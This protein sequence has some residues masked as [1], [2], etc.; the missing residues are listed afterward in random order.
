[1][2]ILD[3]PDVLII[4]AGPSGAIAAGILV[5][6]GWQVQILER[7]QFPRFVIGESLLPQCMAFIEEAGMLDAVNA[8]GFQHKNG[9]AFQRRGEHVV[10]DF[11][12][13]FSPGP[14]TT[15]QVQ[16]AVFDQVLADEA[17]RQ[18]ARIH[19]RHEIIAVDVS[20]EQA[21][22]RY[23]TPEGTEGEIRP[24]FLLDA[25]GYGRVLPRLLDLHRPSNF[26]VRQACFTHVKDGIDNPAFDR[27]KILITTHPEQPD[28]W[29]WTIPFSNG[30]CSLGVV[31]RQEFFAD[32]PEDGNTRLMQIVHED[33]YLSELLAKAEI[34]RPVQ[35][36][37]GYSANVSSLHG[38]HFALLGN[39]GEFLDP[40]FSSGVTVGMKSASLAAGLLNRQLRGESVD[41]ETEFAI[42]LKKGVDAFRT[43]VTGWYDQRFQDIIYHRTHLT[44]VK[45]MICSIL[46]GYAWDE[47]NPYVKESERR[48]NVLAEICRQDR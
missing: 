38:P 36:I 40:V 35:Q 4:G 18:G 43:F 7:E 5:Q 29:Y 24:R 42:P 21:V 23:R 31:A 9:A 39:A 2:N 37:T 47:K 33:P 34:I 1:M 46:A 44:H 27:N 11:R 48:V 10:F 26:P 3:N 17:E 45:S 8:A 22:V 20:G 13:K 6:Q 32:Y 19:Y 41:W 16:R 12:E 25:S 14:G 30:T 15:F 28:V